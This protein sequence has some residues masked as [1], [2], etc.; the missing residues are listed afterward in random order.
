MTA[1]YTIVGFAPEP[2]AT[3]TAGGY[4]YNNCRPRTYDSLRHAHSMATR[5]RKLA[6]EGITYKILETVIYPDGVPTT[7]WVE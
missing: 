1:F 6:R 4:G 5:L 2:F 7:N 3:V